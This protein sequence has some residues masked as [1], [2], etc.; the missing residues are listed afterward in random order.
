MTQFS[1]PNGQS[2]SPS[3][4]HESGNSNREPVRKSIAVRM[5]AYRALH[6]LQLKAEP[7]IDLSYIASAAIEY[8]LGAHNGEAAIRSLAVQMMRRDL[9]ELTP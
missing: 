9:D 6:A 1:S 3:K 2:P 5:D 7:R 8:A 4:Q